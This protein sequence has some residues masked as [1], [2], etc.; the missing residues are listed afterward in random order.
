MWG[1]GHLNLINGRSSVVGT[2][3][4]GRQKFVGAQ[5]S[6]DGAARDAAKLDVASRVA[7]EKKKE[8]EGTAKLE[9]KRVSTKEAWLEGAAVECCSRDDPTG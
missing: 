2:G 7:A 1:Y 4:K 9:E 5:G 3:R 8:E 6:G